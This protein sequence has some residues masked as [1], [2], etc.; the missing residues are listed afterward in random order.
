MSD[1]IL[2]VETAVKWVIENAKNHPGSRTVL[3]G[4]TDEIIR[5]TFSSKLTYNGSTEFY[6]KKQT[7]SLV[8][9]NGS[10]T[11]F[12]TSRAVGG[13]WGDYFDFGLILNYHQWKLP[14]QEDAY[15][16]MVNGSKAKLVFAVS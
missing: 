3:M 14:K 9:P 13:N 2:D 12:A 11:S 16:S 1:V 8:W 10:R 15:R 7:G 4:D 5:S 6:P